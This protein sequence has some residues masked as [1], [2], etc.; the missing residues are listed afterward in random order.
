MLL[1]THSK[2]IV[3]MHIIL[4]KLFEYVIVESRFAMMIVLIS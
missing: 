4:P 2:A 3:S 1:S